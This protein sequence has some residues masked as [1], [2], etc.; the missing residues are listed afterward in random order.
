MWFVAVAPSIGVALAVKQYME[1]RRELKNFRERTSRGRL[2]DYTM[3]HAF[4]VKMGGIVVY[5]MLPRR[6]INEGGFDLNR[7][8]INN[9]RESTS[10]MLRSIDTNQ[11]PAGSDGLAPPPK[12]RMIMSLAPSYQDFKLI[13]LIAELDEY[14]YSVFLKIT[15]NEIIGLSKA[16][17]ITKTFAIVQCTWLVVKSIARTAQGYLISQLELSNV[18]ICLLCNGDAWLLVVQAV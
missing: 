18:G 12:G 13:V 1:A 6:S 17:A 11:Y 9:E 5:D 4:Y 2:D 10:L 14:E 3:A 15:E 7:E 8:I 16:D